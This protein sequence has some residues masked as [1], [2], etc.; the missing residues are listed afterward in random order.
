[1]ELLSKLGIDWKLLVGQIVNFT[2]LL[3]VLLKFVYKPVLGALDR[4]SKMIEKSMHDAHEASEKL[5]NIEKM[6]KQQLAETQKQVGIMLEKA[7]QDAE[8]VKKGIVD[9]A[10]RASDDMLA[11]THTQ[12]KEE[13]TAMLAE[14]RSEL[15]ALVIQAAAKLLDREYSAADQKRLAEAV[16]HEMNSAK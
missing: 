10:R 11:R 5:K 15:S 6:E 1:M 13:K 4:R 2:V 3:I 16:A 8:E 12:L 7:K 9:E 14:A